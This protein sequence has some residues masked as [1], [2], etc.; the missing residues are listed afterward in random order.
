MLRELKLSGV[1]PAPKMEI[2]LR[3]RI[4][5]LTGDN[6]LGKTFLLEIAWW[7]LTRT[8][9]RMPIL[10]P[11]PK[12]NGKPKTQPVPTIDFCYQT[13][14][15][16]VVERQSIYSREKQLWP[17]NQGRP[18]IPGLVIFAQVDGSFSVWDP[19]RNYWRDSG[20][21]DVQRPPAF[22]FTPDIVWEGTLP[23][24]EWSCNGLI[25]DWATW[26]RENGDAFL[27][28]TRV[29]K[30]L[31]PSP[32]E[33]LQPGQLTRISIDDL[34]DHPTLALPYQQDVPLVASSA[35]MRRIVALAYLL[36]WT[37]QEHLRACEFREQEPAKQ[38]IF[39]IDELEAHLHPQW[40]RR[41]VKAL[42][43]VMEVL[44]GSHNSAVQL[45]ATTHSPLVL[46]S[47]EPYFNTKTDA[48]WELDLVENS[49]E[50]T[51]FPWRRVGQVDHWLTSTVFD[52]AEPRSVEA[53]EAM[54][55]A[56]ELLRRVPAPT[57]QEFVSVDEEL[58]KVLGE[59]DR[60][61]VRWSFHLE[62]MRGEQ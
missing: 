7:V 55:K 30:E 32:T 3:P 37:W 15:K 58:R 29:L 4:N 8:W 11:S 34:R 10:P 19:A 44:S 60:F 56:L 25:R 27:Q 59:T 33:P 1:G 48:I 14:G 2:K 31:S 23:G 18:P 40:Q 22:L 54:V 46:A 57:L 36:V 5:F 13:A 17:V 20:A 62:K 26:Q 24:H 35:G 39:L 42:L 28:L 45:I 51:E 16:K 50:L 52:L 21:D 6:G 38:I 43:A 41:I 49:V 9:A 53:E 61:W 47:L 12:G